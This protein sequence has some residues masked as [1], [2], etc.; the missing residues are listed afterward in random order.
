MAAGQ[1]RAVSSYPRARAGNRLNFGEHSSDEITGFVEA[2]I[3]VVAFAAL[4]R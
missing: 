1:L 4:H 2:V 3:N